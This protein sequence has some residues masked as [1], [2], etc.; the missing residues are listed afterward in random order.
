MKKLTARGLLK[1]V[2]ATDTLG[3]GVLTRTVMDKLKTLVKPIAMT[4]FMSPFSNMPPAETHNVAP[5]GLALKK[6]NLAA[7]FSSNLNL[8][9]LF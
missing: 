3:F 2:C 7:N 4:P 9:E 1:V 6:F 5:I 8:I